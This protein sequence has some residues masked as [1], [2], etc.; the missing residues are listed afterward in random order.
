[1]PPLPHTS[2][3]NAELSKGHILRVWYLVKH[4]DSFNFYLYL[5]VLLV[6]SYHIAFTYSPSSVIFFR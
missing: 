5:G 1:M 4:R 6:I 2:S 3:W